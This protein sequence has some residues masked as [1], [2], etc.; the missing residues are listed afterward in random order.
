MRVNFFIPVE[1]RVVIRA[2]IFKLV[3]AK[4]KINCNDDGMRNRHG[5]PVF[6]PVG[7]YMFPEKYSQTTENVV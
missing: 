7:D 3:A 2:K 1:L 6:A 4:D 5:S